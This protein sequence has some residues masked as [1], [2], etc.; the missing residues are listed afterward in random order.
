MNKHKRA[1][2]VGYDTAGFLTGMKLGL[3]SLG[4]DVS[5]IGPAHA[6]NYERKGDTKSASSNYRTFLDKMRDAK[7]SVVMRSKSPSILGRTIRF[8]TPLYRST[9]IAFR[10]PNLLV[11]LL[12]TD[13]ILFNSG[14]TITWSSM[15]LALA[16]LFR[17]K[18]ISCFHGSDI[19]PAYL[20]G[21]WLASAKPTLG[22]I[23]NYVKQ[24]VK[25]AK[26]AERYSD[27]VV[28]WSGITHFLSKPISLHEQ[29]GFPSVLI[30][31][32]N[33]NELPV[34]ARLR[35][36]IPIVLHMPT[37]P[38][39]K[40]TDYIVKE[41]ESLQRSL[42]FEFRVR[43]GLSHEEAVAEI[44]GA[45]IVVDQVYADS[46]SGV[47]ASE[48]SILGRP[49]IIGSK[50][51]KWFR[52][53]LGVDLPA[54][55]FINTIDLR[56]TLGVLISNPDLRDRT[57]EEGHRYFIDRWNPA[58]VALQYLNRIYGQPET[59]KSLPLPKTLTAA[60]GGFSKPE[61]ISL[62][63]T[64]YIQKYGTQ[65]LELDFNSELRDSVISEFWRKS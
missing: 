46:A 17:V 19:R 38:E 20:D 6:F 54:T 35:N 43:S 55:C 26:R 61:N 40:G 37:H 47:L 21:A 36:A 16:R 15:D 22:E 58:S 62:Y 45:D 33:S 59:G 42:S 60:R 51:C 12:K 41:I 27:L 49:V 13:L 64:S 24:Q 25:V 11:I 23:R 65:A 50:D 18:I 9:L 39:A 30:S 14:A 63:V 32:L 34:S 44:Q 7:Q 48:A 5:I 52:L 56:K 4:W 10:L 28:A 8:T 53:T 31:H 2:L 57:A 1:T 29:L 3:T